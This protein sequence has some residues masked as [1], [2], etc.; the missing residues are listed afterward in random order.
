MRLSNQ[1]F[2]FAIRQARRNGIDLDVCRVCSA[3]R[4]NPQE[5]DGGN[6]H[7]CTREATAIRHTLA[8]NV[9]ALYTQFDWA[10]AQPTKLTQW[11]DWYLEDLSENVESGLSVVF[12]STNRGAGKTTAC[13][14]IIQEG[15]RAGMSAYVIKFDD[16]LDLYKH[17]DANDRTDWLLDRDLVLIDEVRKPR[18]DAQL[19]LYEQRLS[20]LVDVRYSAS[21]PILITGNI[22]ED[23]FA[24]AY[25]SVYSRLTECAVF[26]EVPDENF[27]PMAGQRRFT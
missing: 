16:L 10:E 25:E 4:S 3:S 13:C 11:A 8:C 21:K 22:T 19:D 14:Q 7:N 26:V 5:W 17:D 6:D 20:E 2:N 15:I 18:T 23:Q 9:P 1:E 27:R 12:L 24:D